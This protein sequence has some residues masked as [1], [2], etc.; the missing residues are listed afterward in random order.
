M[1]IKMVVDFVGGLA[2]RHKGDQ[3][4]TDTYSDSLD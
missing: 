4:L 2:D 1:R 3:P